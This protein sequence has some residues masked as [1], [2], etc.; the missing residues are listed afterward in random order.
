MENKGSG[1]YSLKINKKAKCFKINKS[2]I[3]I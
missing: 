2:G 3:K 1:I